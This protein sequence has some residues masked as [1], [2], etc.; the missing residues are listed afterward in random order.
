M[1][2]LFA[3]SRSRVRTDAA[4]SFAVVSILTSVKVI[5]SS[6]LVLS[7]FPYLLFAIWRANSYISVSTDRPTNSEPAGADDWKL[8]RHLWLEVATILIVCTLWTVALAAYTLAVPRSLPL[9][10][11]ELISVIFLMGPLLILSHLPVLT[12]EAIEFVFVLI[13]L[14]FAEL[15]YAAARK[16]S[17]VTSRSMS[18]SCLLFIVLIL[19]LSALTEVSPNHLFSA[20]LELFVSWLIGFALLTR[21]DRRGFSRLLRA[22]QWVLFCLISWPT[23]VALY[24]AILNRSRK[25]ADRIA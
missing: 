16:K 22:I 25:H 2:E 4:I 1:P 17:F 6:D 20:L 18:V 24:V 7:I 21:V 23:A 9:N 3:F 13:P 14:F 15:L 5:D 8:R 10:Y 11:W 12:G 19:P